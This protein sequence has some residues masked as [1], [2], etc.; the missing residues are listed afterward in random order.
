MNKKIALGI[1]GSLV[2]AGGGTTIVADQ[3]INPYTDKG[4]T[5][6][7]KYESVLPEA[8]EVKNIVSKDEPKITLEKWNGEVSL[9]VKYTGISPDTK[10]DR[11]F[12]SK[13]VEWKEGDITMQAVPLEATTTMEDGG[14]EINIILDSKPDTNVFTFQLENWENLDFFYQSELTKEEIQEGV[15][16]P[17]NVVGSYAVYY[18]DHANHEVGSTNYTTGKAYHIYRPKVIDASNNEVWGELSYDNGILTV[19]VPQ[20]FL[21]NANYPV[22]VDPDFG[23]TTC[24]ATPVAW[25]ADTLRGKNG[26]PASSGSV[27]SVSACVDFDVG[28]G[29]RDF[30]VVMVDGTALT[31]LTNGVGGV[32]G[33]AGASPAFLTA[34]YSPSPSIVSGTLYYAS[35]VGDS[36]AGNMR[37]YFD[38]GAGTQRIVDTTNSFSTPTNPTDAV[39]STTL[40]SI[41]ATYTASAAVTPNSPSV[42]IKGQMF[43]N[44]GQ[45]TIK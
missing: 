26:T 44:G 28:G 1:F 30:K 23:Y 11:P 13:N 4:T 2:L 42:Q 14:M 15:S 27:T 17:D 18:K 12:L 7:I 21:D 40:Y 8:G 3:Q 37:L 39:T 41:Y 36:G 16:R 29:T 38:A 43:L 32:S 25:G 24:G 34:T 10:G 31:I 20:D 33:A 22:K 19:T 45:A 6:E 9:G 5:L 35:G